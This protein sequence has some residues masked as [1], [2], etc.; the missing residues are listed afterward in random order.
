MAPPLSSTIKGINLSEIVPS[1]E[2][3]DDDMSLKQIEKNALLKALKAASGN[4]EQALRFLDITLR[5]LN[6]KIEK[7][8]INIKDFQ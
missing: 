2:H 4:K 3:Q 7:Y 6:Y 1:I 8:K 5:Q